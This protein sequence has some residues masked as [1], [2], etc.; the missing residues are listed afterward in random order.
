MGSFGFWFWG[1]PEDEKKRTLIEETAKLYKVDKSIVEK[2]FEQI[3]KEAKQI[4]LQ[5]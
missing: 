1:S 5:K 3:E 4:H 2:G